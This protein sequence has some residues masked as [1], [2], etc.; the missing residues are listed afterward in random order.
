[1]NIE[2]VRNYYEKNLHVL[3]FSKQFHFL[4]RYYLWT[5][6]TQYHK[7]LQKH[8][9]KYTRSIYSKVIFKNKVHKFGT[10]PDIIT[11]RFPEITN[12]NKVLFRF[13]FI[14]NIYNEDISEIA[15]KYLDSKELF[16]YQNKILTEQKDLLT[17]S[18]T[19]INFLYNSK[20]YLNHVLP[21]KECNVTAQKLYEIAQKYTE[22]ESLRSQIYYYTHCIINAS[23]FYSKKITREKKVYSDMLLKIENLIKKNYKSI[24]LDNKL[25]FLVCCRILGTKTQ[26][27]QQILSEA[28]SSPSLDGDFIVDT[29]NIHHDNIYKKKFDTSEHRNILYILAFTP[30]PLFD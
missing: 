20:L 1:M 11:K 25:E 27:Q 18:T 28:E 6:N 17:L 21:G 30:S 12:Y 13:L 7:E 2:N 4:S 26:L 14:K 23:E 3:P 29:H 24:T 15:K 22:K 8:K 9:D 10:R 5:N 16:V 19:G